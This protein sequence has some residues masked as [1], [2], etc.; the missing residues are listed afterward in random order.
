MI[1]THTVICEK[2][3]NNQGKE[4]VPSHE[5]QKV[6]EDDVLPSGLHYKVDMT[7][8]EKWAKLLDDNDDKNSKSKALE[9]HPSHSTTDQSD[10]EKT[11]VKVTIAD[12]VNK[13]AMAALNMAKMK[14]QL[15]VLNDIASSEKRES[16]VKKKFR[17]IEE[18]RAELKDLEIEEKPVF[19]IMKEQFNIATNTENDVKSR[20]GAL[21]NLQDYLHKIDFAVDF[22][23]M[24]GAER[25]M[26]MF[27]DENV[28]IRAQAVH[29]VG[30]IMQGNNAVKKQ[31]VEHGIVSKLLETIEKNPNDVAVVKKS[32]F[33]LSCLLRN[34]QLAQIDFFK[35]N[36]FSYLMKFVQKQADRK[37]LIKSVQLISDLYFEISPAEEKKMNITDVMVSNNWCDRVTDILSSQHS[38][39]TIV[40]VV[41]SLEN[42]SELCGD[43]LNKK[44]ALKTFHQ[45]LI[46]QLIEHNLVEPSEVSKLKLLL[47]EQKADSNVLMKIITDFEVRE[48]LVERLKNMPIYPKNDEL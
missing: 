37:L 18:I 4:F 19:D 3:D 12:S 30:V 15:R 5:W 27:T 25:T 34:F 17:S 35:Q 29:I 13:N 26:E 10:N 11:E 7:T 43:V 32:L 16:D 9:V 6:N 38:L 45:I 36:G 21:E 20:L 40:E 28:E 33:S 14:E 47:S 22:L 44:S 42:F 39:D 31:M 48:E 41:T 8:G 2:Q 1:I 46:R 23:K 24:E